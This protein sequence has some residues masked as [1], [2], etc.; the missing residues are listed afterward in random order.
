LYC[1]VDLLGPACRAQLVGQRP[2]D[3]GNRQA[4]HVRSLGKA[5]WPGGEVGA[6]PRWDSETAL[7]SDERDVHLV[8][9]DVAELEHLE[10]AYVG[11]DRV[12]VSESQPASDDAAVDR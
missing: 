7:G 4:E 2:L 12:G 10:C 8:G 5:D 1:E 11:H 3:A 9:D 6:N